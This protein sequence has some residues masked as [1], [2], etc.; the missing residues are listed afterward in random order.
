MKDSHI[1]KHDGLY[2]IYLTVITAALTVLGMSMAF[3]S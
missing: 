1:M 2:V 3:Q